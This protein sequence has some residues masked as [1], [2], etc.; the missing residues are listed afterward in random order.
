[1]NCN[2]V[3]MKVV[4]LTYGK[5]KAVTIRPPSVMAFTFLH[6]FF[7]L[8]WI[9]TTKSNLLTQ[10]HLKNKQCLV[11]QSHLQGEKKERKNLTDLGSLG[12]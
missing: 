3:L 4:V 10:T 11:M 7:V 12:G 6:S 1:M 2:D 5:G 9:P 8:P